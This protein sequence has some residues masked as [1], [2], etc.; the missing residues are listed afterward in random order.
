MA[1]GHI[2]G[3]YATRASVDRWDV[4]VAS[5]NR[6][7]ELTGKK[8]LG[9]VH[10]NPAHTGHQIGDG[11]AVLIDRSSLLVFARD[12]LA[13][14]KSQAKFWRLQLN[15][16][17]PITKWLSTEEIIPLPPNSFFFPV[18]IEEDN[19]LRLTHFTHNGHYALE[20]IQNSS[21]HWKSVRIGRQGD[22]W[23]FSGSKVNGLLQGL[24]IPFVHERWGE[25]LSFGP[26][27]SDSRG[28]NLVIRAPERSPFAATVAAERFHLFRTARI[29]NR[30]TLEWYPLDS[31][32]PNIRPK[33]R[34][35]KS[36]DPAAQVVCLCALPLANGSLAV[37]FTVILDGQAEYWCGHQTGDRWSFEFAGQA[38]RPGKHAQLLEL[39]NGRLLLIIPGADSTAPTVFQSAARRNER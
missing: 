19:S 29:K 24:F 39:G 10:A 6:Q 22:G 23:R 34:A 15:A 4:A 21:G 11:L 14:W 28:R 2:L 13:N 3:T 30:P 31:R 27:Q 8:V 32:N 9:Q 7:G 20:T 33:P 35:L 16:K 25:P 5:W 1:D 18:V 36:F 17:E 26:L 38:D 12:D 37:A